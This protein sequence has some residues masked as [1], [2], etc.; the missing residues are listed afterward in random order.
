MLAICTNELSSIDRTEIGR[1][2]SFRLLKEVF[3]LLAEGEIKFCWSET[4]KSE[5][6]QVKEEQPAA[7]VLF[8]I[9]CVDKE[10]A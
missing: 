3:E 10:S 6:P 1:E 7:F 5:P 2:K 9:S 4:K 8:D